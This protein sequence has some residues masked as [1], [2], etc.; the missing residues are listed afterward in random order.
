M[1]KAGALLASK[2][3]ARHFVCHA[4]RCWRRHA[5][6]NGHWSLQTGN[7]LGMWRGPWTV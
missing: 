2:G 4:W 6:N 1:A 3:A 7:A 5:A